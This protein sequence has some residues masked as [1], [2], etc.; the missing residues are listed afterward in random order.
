MTTIV[1]SGA[2]AGVGRA[3]VRSFAEP[4]VK[5]ALIARNEARLEEAAAEV[6]DAGGAALVLPLDV[7]DPA[8]VE[9][10]AERTEAV[11]GP[12]DIWVN[13]AMVTVLSPVAKM[14]PEEYRRVTDVTYLGTVHGTLA[15]LKRMTARDRGHIVQVGSALAYRVGAAAVGLLRGEERGGRVYRQ[16]ALRVDAR[17]Q[18]READGGASSG[19]QHAAVRLGPQQAGP[20]RPRPVPPVFQPEVIAEGIRHAA[21]HPR[22]EYWLGASSWKAI[23]SEK[24][25]PGIGDRMLARQGYPGQMTNEPED[26]DR[27]DNLFDS[28]DG[29]WAAHGRFDSEA[30]ADSPMIWASEHR[31]AVSGTVAAVAGIGIAAGLAAL[32]GAR[33]S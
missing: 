4:G 8:A 20:A 2:S 1:V 21:Y 12:I 22:R 10:A 26:P 18:Q 6:R 3:V 31:G 7:A 33:R 28:V 24:I 9:S 17:P 19:G 32:I 14:T 30:G 23:L 25:A 15:A 16:P 27:P 13:V 5:I 29:D 11:F